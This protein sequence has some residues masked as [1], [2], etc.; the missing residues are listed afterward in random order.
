MSAPRQEGKLSP[1]SLGDVLKKLE[2]N[3]SAAYL[4]VSDGVS[5]KCLYFSVGAIRL[6]S[7]GKRRGLRLEEAMAVHP[8]VDPVVL[9]RARA[10]Q[11]ETGEPFEE[12]VATHFNL[13]D[14]V[15]ECSTAI[16]RDELLD[17]LVWDGAAFEYAEA[18]PPPK[19]FDPRLEAVKVSFGVAK[20]LKEA[21]DALPAAQKFMMKV[22]A[23]GKLIRG[24]QWA[25]GVPAE[26]ERAA[27]EAVAASISETGA[28][29]EEVTTSA[30]RLGI[31]ALRIMDALDKMLEAKTLDLNAKA[32]GAGSGLTKEEEVQQARQD[33]DEIEGALDL[34]INELVARQRLAR[35]YLAVGDQPK[36]VY[37]LKRVGD[38]LL[39]RNKADEA[40]DAFRQIV[41]I[42]PHDFGVREKI[43][44][45]YER[46]KRVPEAI[47]EGLDLAKL[48]KQF[49]LFNRAKNIFRRV[50]NLDPENV[51]NRRQLIELLVKLNEKPEAVAEYENLAELFS[52]RQQENELLAV[53]QNILALDPAHG[54]ARKQREQIVRRR[55][56]FWVPYVAVAAGFLI[57]VVASAYVSAE[58]RAV[59]AYEQAKSDAYAYA[60][61]EKDEQA[62]ETVTRFLTVYD[63][64]RVAPRA[65]RLKEQ[66]TM[67]AKERRERKADKELKRGK[68][69]EAKGFVPQAR[70]A[71]ERIAKDLYDTRCAAEAQAS[72][73]RIKALDEEA[74]KALRE[75]TRFE[76]DRNPREA[77]ERA[78]ELVRKYP[79]SD[80]AQRLTV[81]LEVVSVPPRAMVTVDGR[82]VQGQTPC[83]IE[84]RVV[85]DERQVAPFILTVAKDGFQPETR[86]VDIRK[87]VAYPLTVELKRGLRWK[88]VTLGPVEAAPLVEDDAV[89]VA[90]RDERVYAYD[91]DGG[92][93][94]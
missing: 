48:Y 2:G 19:I 6:T 20:L 9:E 94:W 76:S 79:W 46:M 39:H 27:C 92:T 24:Q 59:K 32:K 26:G 62:Q 18:N 11:A 91:H 83:T 64:S 3:R 68:Q 82:P 50:I 67:L 22:A 21:A 85:T 23:K 89:Y 51:D 10:R 63:G 55:P 58:Y 13:N 31:D 73:A 71:Y 57:L 40:I 65:V 8:R 87:D 84:Q 49:G 75:V 52:R 15:R 74:D 14:V 80:A 17:L 47:G 60:A 4:L 35:G 90:G 45:L 66:L 34:I 38:E 30:R 25:Y 7:M 93:K 81:R 12:I 44:F 72:V 77:F 16:V 86:E 37:N 41:K 28:T 70:E 61:A 29:L 36:A 33:I 42:V 69:L 43:A 78:R 1:K 54:A 5:E 88:A 56:D 53:Y